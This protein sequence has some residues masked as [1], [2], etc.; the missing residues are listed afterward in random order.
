VPTSGCT[1]GTSLVQLLVLGGG[2]VSVML[3]V[4]RGQLAAILDRLTR[5]QDSRRR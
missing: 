3:T 1:F 5:K 4:G 2:G